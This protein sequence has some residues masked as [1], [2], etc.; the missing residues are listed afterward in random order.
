M[1]QR[2]LKFCLGPEFFIATLVRW[3]F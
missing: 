2:P 1:G 3:T